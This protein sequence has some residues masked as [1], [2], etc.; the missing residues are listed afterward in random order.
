MSIST[1]TDAVDAMTTAAQEWIASLRDDQPQVGH[2]NTPSSDM[3]AADRTRWFYTPTDHGGL[4]IGDQSLEQRQVVMRILSSGLS[5]E[6]YVT[7]AT[8][9]GWENILD[10]LSGWNNYFDRGRDFDPGSYRLR[11]FGEP[12]EP[13]WAWRFG[14]HHLSLNFLIQDGRV[15]STTPS[16][17]G[18]DPASVPLLGGGL[19]R[20]L[21]STEDLARELMLS[22]G[23]GDRRAALLNPKAPAD[24]V[25]SN[26]SYLTEN[27][28]MRRLDNPA[29][30]GREF[31]DYI[32]QG[33]RELA[34]TAE[35]TTGYSSADHETVA[36]TTNPKGLS[37]AELRSDQLALLGQVIGAYVGRIHPALR[38]SATD[39]DA[40]ATDAHFAW[41]GDTE[42]GKP[43]YYR[44]QGPRLLIEYDNTQ[45]DASHAHSLW[46]DPTSD[47]GM[48][49]LRQHQLGMA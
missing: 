21:G 47:F 9:L 19:F 37:S 40:L 33:L 3:H 12:G 15:T 25:T 4:A 22:L 1:H 41:A 14:G 45:R 26:R 32:N 20:P 49:V 36:Y 34:D 2:W 6:A 5:E 38:S 18:T 30:W 29:L 10:R 48:D 7:V 16:F 39:V 8:I 27:A 46:R 42:P 17:L 28:T 23:A 44:V 24:I 31:G 43:M 35:V 11:V 13:M